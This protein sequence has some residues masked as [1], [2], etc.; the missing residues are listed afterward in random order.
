MIDWILYKFVVVLGVIIVWEDSEDKIAADDER[1][2][3]L[4]LRQKEQ[5][6]N[7]PGETRTLDRLI[8][9]DN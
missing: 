6:E 3:W 7:C 1:R 9:S 2:C 5:K 8:I 4:S